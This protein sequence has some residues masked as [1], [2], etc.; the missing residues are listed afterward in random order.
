MLAYM[1]YVRANILA[2]EAGR[3]ECELAWWSA[4]EDSETECP[5][6]IHQPPTSMDKVLPVLK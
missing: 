5:D 3:D 4:R 1:K 6:V 2:W